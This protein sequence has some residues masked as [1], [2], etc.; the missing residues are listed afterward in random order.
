MIEVRRLPCR[1]GMAGFA[2]PAE[3]SHVRIHM[4]GGAVSGCSLEYVVLMTACTH[5]VDMF[6]AQREARLAV[7]EVYIQPVCGLVA[8]GA[9]CPKLSLMAVI[10][11]VAAETI[12]GCALE[13][14]V[15]VTITADCRGMGVRQQEAGACVIEI[16]RSP[17]FWRM[18]RCTVGAQSASMRIIRFVAR[19]TVLRDQGEV[20]FP[21]CICMTLLACDRRMLADQLELK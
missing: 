19:K 10:L 14:Q 5:H 21:A 12:R 6:S 11:C 17:G 16:R 2:L 20:R 9:V 18:A 3:L 15:T 1:R 13:G 7:I 8:R 4:A